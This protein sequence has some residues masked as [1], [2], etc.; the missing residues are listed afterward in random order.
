MRAQL[1]LNLSSLSSKYWLIPGL[2]ALSAMIMSVAVIAIDRQLGVEWIEHLPWLYANEPSGAR[3][4]LSTI[5]GSMITVAGVTFSITIAALATTASTF[6]PRLISNF[7][8]DLGNQI[9]L[10]TFISTFLFCLL[11]LRTVRTGENAEAIFVPHVA[12]VIAM[13]FALASLGVLIYFIHHIPESIHISNVVARLGRDLHAQ[14]EK[15]FPDALGEPASEGE[16]RNADPPGSFNGQPAVVRARIDGYI[17]YVD[18]GGLMKHA[19][20]HDLMIEMRHRPGDFVSARRVVALVRPQV[21]VSQ[22]ILD[23][24]HGA[25]V[26]GGYRSQ[27]QDL[28][29][30]VNRLVEVAARALSP[31]MNDLFTATNAIDWLGAGLASFAGRKVPEDARRDHQGRLRVIAPSR[32]FEE[33]ASVI[34]DQLRPYVASDRNAAVHLMRTLGDVAAETADIERRA[35]LLTHAKALHQAV[36]EAQDHPRDVEAIESAYGDAVTALSAPRVGAAT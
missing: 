20:E 35:V 1:L 12:V 13:L 36:L 34:F 21:R 8:Q 5:A 10:G 9:T 17:Q 31:G 4:L 28:L 22:E 29:Y 27:E 26:V 16:G 19:R 14:V 6:G 24:V 2:M 30:L 3:S 23:A 18:T 25:V 11:V 33:V 15:M 7:M 32:T